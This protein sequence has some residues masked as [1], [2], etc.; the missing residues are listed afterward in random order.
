MGEENHCQNE[1]NKKKKNKNHIQKKKKQNHIQKKK[2]IKTHENPERER[3][4]D[5][6]TWA[7]RDD[8]FR[9]EG[10]SEMRMRVWDEGGLFYISWF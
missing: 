5:L 4:R 1:H 8:D 3:E 10:L 9:D 2:K 7:E 6:H